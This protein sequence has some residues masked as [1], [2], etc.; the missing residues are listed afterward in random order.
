MHFWKSYGICRALQRVA[1]HY[2]VLQYVAQ[3]AHHGQ[4]KS[5]GVCWSVLECVAVSCMQ[6]VAQKALHV[7][8]ESHCVCFSVWL[9]VLHYVSACN[10]TGCAFWQHRMSLLSYTREKPTH[11]GW[12][13]AS[14]M[15]P[16][17]GST[18]RNTVWSTSALWIPT[19][20]NPH[21]LV[22]RGGG[23]THTQAHKSHKK[24]N[25]HRDLTPSNIQINR[26]FG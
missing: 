14:S 8:L 5:H 12:Y 22:V 9:T 24:I 26:V 20:G 23:Q 19:R 18:T 6:C 2:S 11:T 17:C 13:P 16:K 7:L 3:K 25:I 10:S 21:G 1:V 15:T 4:F